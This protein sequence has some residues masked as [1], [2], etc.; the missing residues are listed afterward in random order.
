MML[1]NVVLALIG[2]GSLMTVY[3][4]LKAYFEGLTNEAQQKKLND[5]DVNIEQQQ[6][7]I[8]KDKQAAQEAINAYEKAKSNNTGNS[9]TNGTG[10]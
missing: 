8:I 10:Q 4:R 3:E 9:G 5:L 1:I 7:K 6:N 2:I